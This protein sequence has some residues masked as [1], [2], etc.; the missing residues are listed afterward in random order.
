MNCFYLSPYFQFPVTY[1][2][3]RIYTIDTCCIRHYTALFT[4]GTS[5]THSSITRPSTTMVPLGINSAGF[6][7]AASAASAS[8]RRFCNLFN[9]SYSKQQRG[10]VKCAGLRVV[11]R[12]RIRTLDHREQAS[13]SVEL[14]ATRITNSSS[15]KHVTT[16]LKQ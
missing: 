16:S 5:L 11:P 12:A 13:V 15:S 3:L 2:Q 6:L 8:A 10:L 9:S 1:T 7:R 14:K 4:S